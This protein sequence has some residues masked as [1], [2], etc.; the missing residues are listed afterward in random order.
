VSVRMTEPRKPV[1]MVVLF[2]RDNNTNAE[3]FA[4]NRY[5]HRGWR[6]QTSPI[7]RG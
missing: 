5:V 1:P 6:Y 2:G 7:H 3:R 4:G